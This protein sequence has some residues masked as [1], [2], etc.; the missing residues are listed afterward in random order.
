MSTTDW[1][2]ITIMLLIV[3]ALLSTDLVMQGRCPVRCGQGTR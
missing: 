3:T 2:T 1:I